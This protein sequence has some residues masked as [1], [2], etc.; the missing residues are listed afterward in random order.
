MGRSWMGGVGIV[1]GA[2]NQGPL[3][4]KRVQGA[5]RAHG[6]REPHPKS[7]DLF[8]ILRRTFMTILRASDKTTEG[9]G[10]G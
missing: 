6:P 8:Q 1:G 4:V 5:D 2:S 10:I 3:L 7:G 9:F